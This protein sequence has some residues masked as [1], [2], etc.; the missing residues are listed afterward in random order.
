M[1]RIDLQFTNWLF[2][3][4]TQNNVQRVVSSS[5]PKD[6]FNI[7][8]LFIHNSDNNVF[9]CNQGIGWKLGDPNIHLLNSQPQVRFAGHYSDLCTGM[10]VFWFCNITK[11]LKILW[12]KLERIYFCNF[13]QFKVWYQQIHNCTNIKMLSYPA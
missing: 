1:Y 5:T 13:A 11:L 9:L 4:L 2:F 7:Q 8:L 10:F 3:F 12:E 6:V